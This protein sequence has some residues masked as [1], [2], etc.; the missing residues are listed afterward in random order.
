MEH[1]QARQ[2]VHGPPRII[3]IRV[4]I[5]IRWRRLSHGR[6]PTILPQCNGRLSRRRPLRSGGCDG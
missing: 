3:S 5:L 2:A 4:M 1:F 6:L